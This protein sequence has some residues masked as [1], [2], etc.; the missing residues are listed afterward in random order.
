M[1]L[2]NY[3]VTWSCVAVFFLVIAA[4]IKV[5]MMLER[6][7]VQ[8]TLPGSDAHTARPLEPVAKE[9]P[10]TEEPLLWTPIPG[11]A[12]ARVTTAGGKLTAGARRGWGKLA[13]GPGVSLNASSGRSRIV[14][15]RRVLTSRC[16]SRGAVLTRSP[17]EEHRSPS[18]VQRWCYPRF[19]KEVAAS[20]K[21]WPARSTG[22]Q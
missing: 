21:R 7:P 3:L 16:G 9:E 10:T 11:L 17:G 19:C 20:P 15:R 13:G 8:E 2:W 14:A 18:R 5:G 1:L 4:L 12:E 6:D 22:V